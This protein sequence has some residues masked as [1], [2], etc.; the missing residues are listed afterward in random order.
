MKHLLLFSIVPALSWAQEL[1]GQF[2]YHSSNG[3]YVNNN[4]WGADAGEGE[5]CTYIDSIKDVGVAWHTN[6][7]WSGGDYE[8]KAYPYSGREL[9]NKSLVKDITGLST[10]AEW[11]Y[12]GDDIRANVAYDLFTAADPDHDGS[13]GDYEIM[14][15]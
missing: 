14:I 4:E 13:S 8:V 10:K 11:K 1:C 6:W 15:W 2:D 9:P 3:Y 7:T 12:S 5:Q